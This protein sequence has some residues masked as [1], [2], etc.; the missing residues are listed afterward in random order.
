M[1]KNKKNR[2]EIDGWSRKRRKNGK[3]RKNE[4]K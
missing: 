2:G 1:E 3:W 4:E